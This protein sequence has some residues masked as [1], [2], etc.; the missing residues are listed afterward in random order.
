MEWR[1]GVNVVGVAVRNGE[2]SFW[3]MRPPQKF[4]Y[5]FWAHGDAMMCWMFLLYLR[6]E[7]ESVV[8]GGVA[9]E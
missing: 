2:S 1:M 8:G 7:C 9:V 5:V 4:Y 6:K 3:R